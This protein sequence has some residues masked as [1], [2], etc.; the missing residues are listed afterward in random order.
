MKAKSHYQRVPRTNPLTGWIAYTYDT[1]D[2][3][4]VPFRPHRRAWPRYSEPVE[5]VCGDP[6]GPDCVCGHVVWSHP[7]CAVWLAHLA[8][9]RNQYPVLAR[10]LAWGRTLRIGRLIF[11][12]NVEANEAIYTMPRAWVVSGQGMSEG[13]ADASQVSAAIA[14]RYDIPAYVHV[15][16]RTEQGA[17]GLPPWRWPAGLKQAFCLL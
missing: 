4:I 12:E 7:R 15:C 9:A 11:A 2:G 5:H 17:W 1:M 13:V 8:A 14:Q 10:V 6:W 3:T 16:P